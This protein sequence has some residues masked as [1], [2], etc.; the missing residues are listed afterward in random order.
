[1]PTPHAPSHWQQPF[2]LSERAGLFRLRFAD[3]KLKESFR[4]YHLLEFLPRL[5][6]TL[7]VAVFCF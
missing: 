7:K 1:M 2:L 6:R 3:D 5:K 4:H